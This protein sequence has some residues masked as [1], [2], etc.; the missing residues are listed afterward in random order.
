MKVLYVGFRWRNL[1][2]EHHSEDL[3]VDGRIIL[4]WILKEVESAWTGLIWL[5]I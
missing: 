3:E 1:R 5:R 2:E 4:E